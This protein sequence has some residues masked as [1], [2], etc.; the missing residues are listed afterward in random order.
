[1]VF[2]LKSREIFRKNDKA[3]FGTIERI[4]NM[5]FNLKSVMNNSEGVVD[6]IWDWFFG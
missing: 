2:Q 4:Q 3:Y 6:L 5:P 1:M